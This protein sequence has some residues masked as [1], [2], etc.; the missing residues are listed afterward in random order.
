MK[1]YL[2]SY[3][4]CWQLKDWLIDS[5]DISTCQGLFYAKRL[6][7]CINRSIQSIDGT[8]IGT[9]TLGLNRPGNNDNEGVLH[10]P[11]HL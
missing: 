11:P 2:I 5:N 7:N 6:G 10:T 8:L 4:Y 9:T 1:R 3:L